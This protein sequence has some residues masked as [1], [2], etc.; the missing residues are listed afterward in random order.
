MM[1]YISLYV[2]DYHPKMS[3]LFKSLINTNARINGFEY[4]KA[5]PNNYDEIYSLFK[6][7][8]PEEHKILDDIIDYE[9]KIGITEE[10]DRV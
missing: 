9:I 8:F 10:N 7:S 6:F 5:I 1:D 2:F 4:D 3:F